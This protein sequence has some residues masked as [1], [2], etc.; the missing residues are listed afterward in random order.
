M[1]KKKAMPM[2]DIW[3]EPPVTKEEAL[4]PSPHGWYAPPLG[5][6]GNGGD[7]P[8]SDCDLDRMVYPRDVGPMEKA[9]NDRAHDREMQA[10]KFRAERLARSRDFSISEGNIT[11][12]DP[13]PPSSF[14]KE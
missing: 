8:P 3:V 13:G 10:E 7:G 6:Q 9:A 2:M 14:G 12:E 11:G 5:Y 4:N 1:A